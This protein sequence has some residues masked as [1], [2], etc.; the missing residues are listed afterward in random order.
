MRYVKVNVQGDVQGV[1]FRYFT[2]KM[3]MKYT[4]V[5]WVKNERDGSVLIK[6]FGEEAAISDF[7]NEI[8][9]GPPG[10]SVKE[11]DVT[12][13]KDEPAFTDFRITG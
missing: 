3:A 10:S 12:D 11:M 2:Q 1:G 5:G 4:I 6:A 9:K 7:L 13:L 8:K